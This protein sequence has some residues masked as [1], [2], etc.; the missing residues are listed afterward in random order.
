V[1]RAFLFVLDSFGIGGAPDAH[2]FV[3]E[4]KSDLGSNTWAQ[5]HSRILRRL[6]MKIRQVTKAPVWGAYPFRR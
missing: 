4:G 5:I 2:D 3:T 6:V 1:A